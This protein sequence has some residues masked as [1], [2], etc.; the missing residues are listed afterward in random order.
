MDGPTIEQMCHA[1]ADV[2]EAHGTDKAKEFAQQLR[3]Q[4]C[5]IDEEGFAAIARGIGVLPWQLA[6]A[7][8]VRM[9]QRYGYAHPLLSKVR[10]HEQ[11][12][13]Q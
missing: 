6:Q 2:L 7:Y 5:A 13:L 12:A 1:L 10:L 4:P 3:V 11:G 8:L 9:A